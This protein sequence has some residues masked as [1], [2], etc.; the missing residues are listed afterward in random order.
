MKF[1]CGVIELHAATNQADMHSAD[2]RRS[3]NLAE[4]LVK[5]NLKWLAVE[6]SWYE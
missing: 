1:S 4:H 2:N 5:G 6:A 3:S